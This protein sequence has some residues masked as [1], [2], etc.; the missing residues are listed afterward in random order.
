MRMN[1]TFVAASII[2]RFS[3]RFP[4]GPEQTRKGSVE[5]SLH[6]KQYCKASRVEMLLQDFAALLLQRLYKDTMMP[7]STYLTLSLSPSLR[8]CDDDVGGLSR[9]PFGY[10]LLG[11]V[12]CFKQPREVRN[13][14][15]A[16][17]PCTAFKITRSVLHWYLDVWQDSRSSLAGFTELCR[18]IAILNICLHGLRKL[19]RMLDP[20]QRSA[21]V[22]RP[23]YILDLLQLG[24][25]QKQ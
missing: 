19:L 1:S 8:T 21:T 23:R 13:C 20:V 24:L 16:T 3:H 14:D 11:S 25:E 5:G 22:H 4:Y 15:L 12:T 2:A 6:W 18:N 9:R 10:S 7:G 17:G